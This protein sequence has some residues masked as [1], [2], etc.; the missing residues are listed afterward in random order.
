MVGRKLINRGPDIKI[1]PKS[2]ALAYLPRESDYRKINPVAVCVQRGDDL[3]NKAPF[4]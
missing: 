2:G 1:F 4:F 3:K